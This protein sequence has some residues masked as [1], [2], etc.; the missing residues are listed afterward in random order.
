MEI[1]YKNLN[2]IKESFKLFNQSYKKK[3]KAH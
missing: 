3:V 2:S 1:K